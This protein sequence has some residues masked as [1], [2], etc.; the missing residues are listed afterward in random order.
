M[1][2]ESSSFEPSSDRKPAPAAHSYESALILGLGSNLGQSELILERAIAHLSEL[3]GVLETAPFYRTAPVSPI[4]QADFINTV[5]IAPRAIIDGSAQSPMAVLEQIKLLEQ[6]AGRTPSL[7]PDGP[8]LLDIDLLLFGR[9]ELHSSDGRLHVPHCRLRERR[10]V[11][12]PLCDL[13]PRL[14][15]PPDGALVCDLLA[16][17]FH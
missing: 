2:L 10:F 9:V 7:L 17:V 14:P 1:N 15:I 13:A 8:R 5:V 16:S 12:Q 6:D 4:V 11:L 3:F